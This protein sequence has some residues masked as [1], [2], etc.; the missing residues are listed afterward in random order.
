MEGVDGVEYEQYDFSV[1]KSLSSETARRFGGYIA[2]I[3]EVGE[4][5]K[6]EII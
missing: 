2:P 6:Q 1:V 3:F 4:K 5:T